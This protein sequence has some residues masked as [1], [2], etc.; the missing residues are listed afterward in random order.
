MHLNDYQDRAQETNL[1]RGGDPIGFYIHALA[2]EVG[3]LSSEY[4]KRLRDGTAHQQF[5]DRIAEELGDILWY[6]SALAAETGFDLDAIAARNLAKVEDRWGGAYAGP[7]QLDAGAPPHQQLPRRFTATFREDGRYVEVFDSDGTRLGNRLS[8]NSRDED[9]YRYHDAFHLAHSAVL[10]W[11][12]VV[13]A[14]LGRKRKDDPDP[15]VDEAEDG[16]R[17]I[18]TE[19]GLTAIVFKWAGQNAFFEGVQHIDSEILRSV[20]TFVTGFE[21]SVRSMAEWESAILQGYE[22]WRSLVARGGGT[23]V[24]DLDAGTIATASSGTNAG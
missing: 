23:V 22:V 7:V 14:M 3:T 13:R 10:G 21:V 15:L 4:K 12:P 9:H 2:G 1:H 24:C 8:D 17:A 5:N 16:A 19:E 20:Q 6:A 18:F 11:S